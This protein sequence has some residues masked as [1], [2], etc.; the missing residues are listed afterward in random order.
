MRP[1]N[2]TKCASSCYIVERKGKDGHDRFDAMGKRVDA[3]PRVAFG[4]VRVG[5]M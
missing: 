1:G 2:T 3:E 4:P 5:T